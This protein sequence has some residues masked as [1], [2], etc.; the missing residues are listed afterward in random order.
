M[1]EGRT[2]IGMD[3]TEKTKEVLSRFNLWQLVREIYEYVQ[4][5]PWKCTQDFEWEP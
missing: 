4:G 1:D 2:A 5:N 3:V